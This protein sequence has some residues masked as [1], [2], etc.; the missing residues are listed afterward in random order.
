MAG[1]SVFPVLWLV[2]PW[3]RPPLL[4]SGRVEC[5]KA[6]ILVLTIDPNGTTVA[7]AGDRTIK[8]W[9]T[10]LNLNKEIP[11]A[12]EHYITS[13][14]FTPDHKYLASGGGDHIINIWDVKTGTKVFGPFTGHRGDV[15][16]VEFFPMELTC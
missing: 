7:S 8:L 11:N 5:D 9:D 4:Q 2:G 1:P 10:K 3:R 15:E 14:R 6:E 12:H 16:E 13:M